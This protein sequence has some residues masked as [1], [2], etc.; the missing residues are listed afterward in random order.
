M[1]DDADTAAPPPRCSVCRGTG[2]VISNLG[3]SP[4]TVPCPWC[5]GDGVFVRE[6]DAQARW[7]KGPSDGVGSAR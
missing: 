4:S 2:Q 1:A 7:R 3:G 5:E 6:H